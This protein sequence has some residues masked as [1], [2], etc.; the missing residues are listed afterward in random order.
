MEFNSVGAL[1]ELTMIQYFWKELKLCIKAEIDQR[2]HELDSFEELVDKTI[3]AKP[4]SALRA[5]SNASE[6]DHRC[7]WGTCLAY[8]AKV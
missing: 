1:I 3:K 2:N 8:I 5:G 6:T 7:L 4:K